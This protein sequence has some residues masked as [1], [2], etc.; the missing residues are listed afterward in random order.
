MVDGGPA[1]ERTSAPPGGT[2]LKDTERDEHVPPGGRARR[3][4]APRRLAAAL[5]AAAVSPVLPG[6]AHLRAGRVRLGAALLGVQA[7]LLTA[8]AIAA[9][10]GR[11]LVL[12]LSVRPG[13]LLAVAVGS[14]VL[15]G[16]W[17]ALIIHSYAVLVPEDL[18][19]P[20]RLAGAAAVSVLCLLAV[21]PPVTVAHFGRLQRDLVTGT[22]AEEGGAGAAARPGRPSAPPGG[23]P[24]ARI[25]RLNVLLIGGDADVGRPGIRTDSMTLASID[26]RTGNTVL[27][28]LPRN[29]Q[30]VPVW[31]GRKRIAFPDEELLNAVYETGRERPQVLAG[32]GRVRDPGAELLK[33]TVGHILGQPVPYYAMVDMRSFRQIVDAVGGVRVCVAKPIPVPRQQVPAGVLKPGCRRL[34]GREA[35]WYG[36]SRTGSS[37]YARMSRQKC[38]IWALA[39]QA[40]PLT[41]LRSFERLSGVFKRSVSTD[42]PRRLL[43]PLVDLAAKIRNAEITS[44]QF[45]PP[46]ISTGRPDYGKIRRMAGKAIRDSE[47]GSHGTSGLHILSN[48]CT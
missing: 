47:S 27:L 15:A 40:G 43:P 10:H 28:S 2:R 14:V 1:G 39:R 4:A 30:N 21:V 23:D 11:S 9:G 46:V 32:G 48:S 45:V 25:P 24:W 13:W 26:T 3:D 6:V 42:V 33:R 34:S 5:L 19:P 35:L 37:D 18:S 41:V 22:F 29:L 36:R 20:L 12:E 17:A 8:V 31:S 16:L 7:V 38:L 44:L